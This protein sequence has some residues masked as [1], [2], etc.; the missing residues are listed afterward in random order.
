MKEFKPYRR[1]A[2]YYETDRMDIVHHSNYIRW[3]EEAR[4]DLMEQAGCPFE[5]TEKQGILSPVLS[6]SAEYKYPV[7]FGDE[8]EVKCRLL[9][10]NG[11]R[12]ELEYEINNITTGQLSCIAR[13]THCFTG[14]DLRPV[15]MQKKFPELYENLR[16][17]LEDNEE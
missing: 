14:T 16:E 12:F 11:C 6:V 7:R 15:R 4:V 8:F 17:A 10:F 3:L 1:K 2:Y 9:S 5:L 13:T